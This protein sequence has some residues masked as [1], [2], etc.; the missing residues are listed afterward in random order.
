VTALAACLAI[1][2]GLAGSVQV[3][4]MARLGERVGIFGALAW[5]TFLTA[6]IAFAVLLVVHQGAGDFVAAARQ[7]VWLWTGGVMGVLIVLTITFAG[8]RIGVA[9]TVGILIAGQLA[10]GTLIDRFGLFGV[11]RVA[12]S[13]PRVIGIAL[14]AAGAALT[15]RR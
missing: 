11:Q 5:A 3:A 13:W 7:P 10:M 14:L 9:A 8:S 12:I 6:A 2:A 1:V 15:L 4:V